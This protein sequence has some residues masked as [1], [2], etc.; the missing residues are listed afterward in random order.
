M[1]VIMWIAR[2]ED[3]SLFMYQNKPR[4]DE[5]HWYSTDYDL[6]SIDDTLFPEI[7]WEDP[8]PTEVQIEIKK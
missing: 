1:K 4:K 7:E 5:Y 3:G 6:F 2:D 8:E